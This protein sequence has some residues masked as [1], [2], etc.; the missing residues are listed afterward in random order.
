VIARF[1]YARRAKTLVAPGQAKLREGRNT[2]YSPRHK[3]PPTPSSSASWPPTAQYSG[4]RST[5]SNWGPAWLHASTSPSAPTAPVDHERP[6]PPW[7]TAA[8]PRRATTSLEDFLAY[9]DS[10][11]EQV[12]PH[13]YHY[14]TKP[15]CYPSPCPWCGGRLVHNP[16]CDE[17]RRSWEP[18]MPFGKHQGKPLSAVPPDY[19]DWLNNRDGI[20][21]DLQQAIRLRLRQEADAA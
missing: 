14:L 21:A 17:L 7:P 10:C 12:Y 5:R 13:D 11:W 6:E 9:S 8:S 3:T 20:P 18:T 16:H 15:R 4:L 1:L 2:T 19:L